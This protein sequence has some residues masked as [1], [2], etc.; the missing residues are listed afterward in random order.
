MRANLIAMVQQQVEV[1]LCSL[2]WMPQP[3]HHFP[4]RRLRVT[5][6]SDEPAKHKHN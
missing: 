6:L 1:V 4:L 2:D 3:L 5:E